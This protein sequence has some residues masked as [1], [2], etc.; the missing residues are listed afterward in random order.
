[1][2]KCEV[3]L[4]DRAETFVVPGIDQNICE[5]CLRGGR[6]SELFPRP[7]IEAVPFSTTRVARGSASRRAIS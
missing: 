6:I 4:K 3:C 7:G 2:S 5:A 1:M